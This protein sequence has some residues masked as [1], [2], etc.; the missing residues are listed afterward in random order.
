MKWSEV[1]H[2]IVEKC[3]KLELTNPTP[4]RWVVTGPGRG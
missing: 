1:K 3:E 2:K 4:D